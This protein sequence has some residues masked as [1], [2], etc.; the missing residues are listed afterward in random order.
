MGRF[1]AKLDTPHPEQ[2]GMSVVR[3]PLRSGPEH[4]DDGFSL[5]TCWSASS[6]A[7][8]WSRTSLQT[9]WSQLYLPLSHLHVNDCA[10]SGIIR[11][12]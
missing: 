4:N 2:T 12:N 5:V 9:W 8:W 7:T 3:Q 6:L 10:A 1:L 11:D